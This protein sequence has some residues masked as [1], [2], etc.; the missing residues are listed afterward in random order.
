MGELDLDP[1]IQ[2]FSHQ[3]PLE[4]INLQQLQR[5]QQQQQQQQTP[6]TSVSC[7]G[8][9]AGVLG[10]V[11]YI[12]KTCNYCLHVSCSQMPRRITHPADGTHTLTLLTS[13]VYPEGV[14]RCDACG[15]Q[16]KGFCFHCNEC[17][18]DIHVDCAVLPLSVAHRAHLHPLTLAFRSPYKKN[19]FCC[20][21]CKGIGLNQWLYRCALCSFDAHLDCTSKDSQADSV[22]PTPRTRR[23]HGANSQQYYTSA[24]S[25]G[26]RLVR[27]GVEGLVEGIAQQAGQTLVQAVLGASSSN[28][29]SGPDINL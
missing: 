14:F 25:F 26:S 29:D 19:S 8:C 2:H 9:K 5:Q 1:V 16:G 23:V 6:N 11:I 21:I 17:Q 27:H 20:D 24:S 4:L 22:S 7:S 13:P 12:C 10:G 3:H 15:R 28:T 18:L